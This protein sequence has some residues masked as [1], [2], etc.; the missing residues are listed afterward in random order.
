[1]LAMSEWKDLRSVFRVAAEEEE[2][3]PFTVLPGAVAGEDG[4]PEGPAPRWRASNRRI[5]IDNVD[6]LLVRAEEAMAPCQTSA[7]WAAAIEILDEGFELAPDMRGMD[8]CEERMRRLNANMR[9]AQAEKQRC[10][11]REATDL[12][13]RQLLEARQDQAKKLMKDCLLY[14]SPSPRDRG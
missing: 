10:E 3:P 11:E 8:G 7:D 2:A 14:T 12:E 5:A 6:V 13:A 9:R 1:M 4:E